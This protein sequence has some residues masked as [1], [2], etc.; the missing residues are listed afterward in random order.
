[1]LKEFKRIFTE[2]PYKTFL[3]LILSV[4]CLLTGEI[5]IYEFSISTVLFL[6]ILAS[7][8]YLISVFKSINLDDKKNQSEVN[9]NE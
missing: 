4:V 7:I 1:M 5:S 3:L 9:K 6:G 8:A 2:H